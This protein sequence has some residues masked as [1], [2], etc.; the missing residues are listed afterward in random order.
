MTQY[1]EAVN[2]I[3]SK[4]CFKNFRKTHLNPFYRAPQDDCFY[5]FWLKFETKLG[6]ISVG[7]FILFDNCKLGTEAYSEPCQTLKMERF[8]KIVNG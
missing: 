2:Y 5:G 3:S 8:A 7:L 1:T 6:S 4:G